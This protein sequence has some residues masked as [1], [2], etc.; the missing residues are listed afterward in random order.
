M[1]VD[2]LVHF[3][4]WRRARGAAVSTLPPLASPSPTRGLQDVRE[5][6]TQLLVDALV[7]NQQEFEAESGAEQSVEEEEA[8]AATALGGARARE[9]ARALRRCSPLLVRVCVHACVP[10]TLRP[11]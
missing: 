1:H 7:K 4:V 10:A 2:A 5:K 9:V 11:S 8:A 6:A 3:G